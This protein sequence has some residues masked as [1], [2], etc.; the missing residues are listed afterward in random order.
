MIKNCLV[1]NKE[2]RT[3]PSA[4]KR[5]GGKY[6][7]EKCSRTPRLDKIKRICL[8]CGKKFEVERCLV[9]RGKGKYCS[10]DCLKKR[11]F[12]NCLVCGKEFWT[13][14]SYIKKGGGKYCSYKCMGMSNTTKVTKTC[15]F[16]KKEFKTILAK[17]KTNKFCSLRC[18]RIFHSANKWS[19]KKCIYCHKEFTY[20][21]KQKDRSCCS[22]SCASQYGLDKYQ[23]RKYTINKCLICLK[24]IKVPPNRIRSGRGKYCSKEC[25]VKGMQ[26]FAK[27]DEQNHCWKGGIT[28][29]YRKIRNTHSYRRW[30]KQVKERDNFKCI[31]CQSMIKI[32]VD[33]IKSFDEIIKQHHIT[34]V[35]ES[36]DCKE[37]FDINNGRTLCHICHKKTDTYGYTKEHFLYSKITI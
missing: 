18:Y 4:I 13:T 10:K 31:W 5:G 9:N 12:I 25:F 27:F 37:L 1:C 32:E 30:Q 34:T 17:E 7:S 33:H 36:L 15:L 28:P 14:P 20:R 21:T 11:V 16:C 6:C 23:K 24:E 3:F 26:K 22:L 8:T 35:K 19:T 2:F 29:L